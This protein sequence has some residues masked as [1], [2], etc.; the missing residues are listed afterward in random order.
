M[1]LGAPARL[2]P[3]GSCASKNDCAHPFREISASGRECERG[4][5]MPG[6]GMSPDI[7]SE[8]PVGTIGTVRECLIHIFFKLDILGITDP[9]IA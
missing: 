3:R 5:G 4:V 9:N 1:R 7:V 6:S 2:S 8:R